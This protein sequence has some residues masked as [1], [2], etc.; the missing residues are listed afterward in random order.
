MLE[1]KIAEAVAFFRGEP[2]FHRLFL[3]MKKKYQSLGRVGGTV[4]LDGFSFE[5]K[6]AI[7]AF[8]G[9]DFHQETSPS[10]SL[11]IFTEQLEKTRF[12]GIP[13]V[14]LLESYFGEDITTNQ[15]KKETD[16]K[17]KE[18]FF[19]ILIHQYPE[20]ARLLSS[21]AEAAPQNRFIHIA[22]SQD[23]ENLETVLKNVCT[24]LHHLPKKGEYERLSIF[25][26]KVLKDPHAFDLHTFQGKVFLHA[27]QF[28]SDQDYDLSSVEEVNE[29]L[30]S[31]GILRE[32]ILNFVT[33][34]G[35][36]AE[37]EQGIHPVFSSAV[38][39]NS[40]L[41]VPLREI[42]KLKRAY[43]EKGQTVF[44]VENSGVFSALLDFFLDDFPPMIC[45]NGQ[46]KLASLILIDLLIKEG[47]HIYYSGDFDPEGLKMAQRL[48]ERNQEHIHLW[49]FQLEDYLASSPEVL[50][51]EDRVA[52]L[53]SVTLEEL[54]PVKEKI[55]KMKKAGYQEEILMKLY[56]DIYRHMSDYYKQ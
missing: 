41:N 4:K 17:K 21:L 33:C 46:F 37:A 10:V 38:K 32:E 55:R 44:V 49:Y 43:P 54:Q 50:L 13:F 11:K 5:E 29:L 22:Y 2:G 53:E 18:E 39:T 25:S 3:L 40:V 35:I 42:L 36:L 6:E 45:T 56:E 12:A 47:C 1:Q 51:S 24:A 31:F 15:E 27:L 48:K 34:A 7:G 20:Q 52:K 14:T 16:R 26:Q 19:Q 8:F 30:Q 9:K 28:Y 23:W